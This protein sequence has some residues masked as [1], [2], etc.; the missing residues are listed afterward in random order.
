MAKYSGN[1]GNVTLS[2]TS[3]NWG[4]GVVTNNI[5]AF[6]ADVVSDTHDVTSFASAGFREYTPGNQSG[7]LSLSMYADDTTAIAISTASNPS[8]TLKLYDGASDKTISGTAI[9]SNISTT[10]DGKS[11]DAPVVTFKAVFSGTITIA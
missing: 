9:L 2:S 3:G 10:V 7:T 5:Y 1:K 8:V 6:S 11:G 4:G